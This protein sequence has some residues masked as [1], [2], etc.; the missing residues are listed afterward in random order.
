M[1]IVTEYSLTYTHKSSIEIKLRSI[2]IYLLKYSMNSSTNRMWPLFK[3]LLVLFTR[4]FL[5]IRNIII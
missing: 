5:I 4:F 1:I 2:L 3:S